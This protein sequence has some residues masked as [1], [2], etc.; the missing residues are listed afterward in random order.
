GLRFAGS[1]VS[2]R[3]ARLTADGP[4]D[5]LPFTTQAAGSSGGGAWTL[6]GRGVFSDARPGYAASFD[7]QGRLGGRELRTLEPALLRFGGPE[8][9]ARLKLAAS[10]GG[11]IDLDGRLS[12]AGADVRAQVTG[13]TLR[14]LDEDLEGRTDATLNLQG[15][16]GRLDGTLEAKLAG[17]RGRGTPAASGID[18][19]VRGRLTA[20]ALALD[21]TAANAQ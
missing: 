2:V 13:L 5:R 11:R 20:G 8:R 9:S 7:G 1:G 15:R 12:E 14:L 21:M 10:D 17:A 4:L 19:V 18:G 6:G 3:S 16:G